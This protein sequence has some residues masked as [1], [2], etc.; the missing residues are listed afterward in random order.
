MKKSLLYLAGFLFYQIGNAQSFIGFQTDNYN[1]IHA[2]LSNPANL[3][4]SPYTIDFNIAGLSTFASTNL[5]DVDFSSDIGEQNFANNI[6]GNLGVNLDILGP[7][8]LV[9]IDNKNA[10]ALST[11]IRTLISADEINSNTLD[12]FASGIDNNSSFSINEQDAYINMNMWAEFGISYARVLYKDKEHFIKGGATLKLLQGLGA[13]YANTQ[14]ASFNYD[15]DNSEINSTGQAKYAHTENLEDA[16]IEISDYETAAKSI[17]IDLGASYEYRPKERRF[18]EFPYL[19]KGGISIMD[20]GPNLKYKKATTNDIDLNKNISQ[21]DFNGSKLENYTA[22][23]SIESLTMFLPTNV[24]LEA[25]WN[26]DHRFFLNFNTNFSLSRNKQDNSTKINNRLSITPRWQS[27]WISAYLPISAYQYSKSLQAGLGV[28]L[29]P[30]YIGSGSLIS[31]L[32]SKSINATDFYIGLKAPIFNTRKR[33]KRE[34][35]IEVEKQRNSKYNPEFNTYVTKEYDHIQ[36]ALD[37]ARAGIADTDMDGVPDVQDRCPQTKGAVQNA[38]C[39]VVNQP[40]RAQIEQEPV[41][42]QERY[43]SDKPRDYQGENFQDKLQQNRQY[44]QNQKMNQSMSAADDID[45]IRTIPLDELTSEQQQKLSDYAHKIE[46]NTAESTLKPSSNDSLEIITEL[47]K[48]HPDL[49]FI[50]EGHTDNQGSPVNN[51]TLSM[52]R[53]KAVKNYLISRG[54]EAS[55]LFTKGFGSQQPISDNLTEQ[56]RR[57]NRRVEIHVM[58]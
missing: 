20:I 56:G 16:K 9:N 43:Y 39:P 24:R 32:A 5:V 31:N 36:Y 26:I 14:D 41:Q 4:D 25:D 12:L 15:Q 6:E 7:S 13:T 55:R 34:D 49:T 45:Q 17:A 22:N 47:I 28:R 2:V 42:Q 30:L 1:G 58:Q 35:D 29:G 52:Y 57:E 18:K 3:V 21:N 54:I 27:K 38:G 8:A 40:Q 11:R 19:V 51:L 33:L 37:N 23:S 44:I 10:I 48:Q 53:A 50:I 46:F